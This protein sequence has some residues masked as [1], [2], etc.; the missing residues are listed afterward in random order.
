MICCVTAQLSWPRFSATIIDEGGEIDST[1]VQLLKMRAEDISK[2]HIQNKNSQY[3]GIND[4]KGDS[5]KMVYHHGQTT[6]LSNT[7]QMVQCLK[8]RR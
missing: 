5:R 8:V 6:D 7:E 3:N 1:F 4:S 2:P